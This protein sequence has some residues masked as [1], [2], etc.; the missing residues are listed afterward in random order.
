[1]FLIHFFFCQHIWRFIFIN[2]SNNQI[3]TLFSLLPFI[4]SCLFSLF[5][6]PEF[7][8]SLLLQVAEIADL[9]SSV[10]GM[11]ST[12]C[13]KSPLKDFFNSYQKCLR[14][15]VFICFKI[16]FLFSFFFNPSAFRSMYL[17]PNAWELSSD[18]FLLLISFVLREHTLCCV[19]HFKFMKLCWTSG[20]F[21]CTEVCWQWLLI[22]MSYKYE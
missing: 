11:I 3:L 5:Y 4:C 15:F 2:I 10:L 13:D 12:Y 16:V 8:I 19:R 20:Y 6:S 18:A 9:G 21:L 17:R 14:L 7:L 22:G 1:M